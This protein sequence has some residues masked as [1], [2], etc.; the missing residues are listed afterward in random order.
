MDALMD[1]QGASSGLLVA[2]DV[3]DLG[4]RSRFAAL[5]DIDT[6]KRERVFSRFRR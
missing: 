5:V 6:L 1:E 3:T 2:L 4:A